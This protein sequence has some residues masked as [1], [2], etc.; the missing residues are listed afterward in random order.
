[1]KKL[2]KLIMKRAFEDGC[3][4][5]FHSK[6]VF[7]NEYG[8]C[9]IYCAQVRGGERISVSVCIKGKYISYSNQVTEKTVEFNRLGHDELITQPL[10]EEIALQ[11]L[12]IFK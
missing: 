8:L 4:V 5:Y 9:S 3:C 6:A 10:T 2:I 7:Q 12:K 11:I 1:M